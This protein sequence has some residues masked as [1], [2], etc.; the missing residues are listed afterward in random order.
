MPQ[1]AL[2]F[3]PCATERAEILRALAAEGLEVVLAATP[4]EVLAKLDEGDLALVLLAQLPGRPDAGPGLA[5]EVS[6]RLPAACLVLIAPEPDLALAL[7]AIGAGADNLLVRPLHHELVRETCRRAM[8]GR[9]ARTAREERRGPGPARGRFAGLL[10]ASR[11]MLRVFEVLER[12]I[13]SDATILLTGETGTGKDVVAQA[14]HRE[15]ARREGPFLAINCMALPGELLESELFGHV[16]GAFTGAQGSRL[17]LFQRAHRG[18]VFLDEIGD[19]AP[20]LQGKLLRA[21]ETRRIRPVGGEEEVEVDVRL[22]SATHRDLAKAIEAGTFR[23][24]LFFRLNVVHIRLPPLRE[25]GDDILLLA[26]HFLEHAAARAGKPLR[27]FSPRAAASLCRHPWPGNVREL[28]NC[29]ESAV[30]LA[31]GPEIEAEDLPEP[32]LSGPVEAPGG[33]PPAY[34]PLTLAEVERRHIRAVLEATGGNRREAARILGLNRSTLYRKIA[35]Y[36]I[37]LD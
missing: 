29:V 34:E 12:A 35:L 28:Q 24:D 18:T 16:A 32:A 26:R 6:A 8:A 19:M 23:Q 25:R 13:A 2:V 33:G 15:G 17:G 30:A 5:R 27:G 31:D 21:L 3:E 22:V 9:R 20:G 7:D 37:D 36:R 11:A 4:D 10:G 1:R 14:I